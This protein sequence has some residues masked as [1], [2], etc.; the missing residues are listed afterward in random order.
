MGGAEVKEMG[1]A[2]VKEMGG[3]EVRGGLSFGSMLHNYVYISFSPLHAPCV[4]V[5]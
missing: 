5:C 2:E 4:V 3:T 1:G